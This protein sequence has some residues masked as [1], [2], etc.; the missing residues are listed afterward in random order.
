MME[1]PE[2]VTIASQLNDTVR[3]KRIVAATA[4]HTPHRFAWYSGDPSSYNNLVS[5]KTVEGCAGYGSNVEIR[6]GD[7]LLSIGTFI[8]FHNTGEVRPKIHQLLLEFE[9]GSAISACAQLWGGFFCHPVG[10]KCGFPDVD[11]AREKPS[12]LSEGFNRKYFVLLFDAATQSLSA[13]AFLATQQRIPGL[14]NG[15]LQDILWKAKIHPKTKMGDSSSSSTEIL[16][17]SIKSVLGKM[18]EQGGRDTERDLFNHPGGYHTILS[19][20]TVGT[21]CP[22]CGALICKETYMGGAIY[23]CPDCQEI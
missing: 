9:D 6:A 3:G 21:P 8:L 17:H 18:V 2:A 22:E 12:P 7:R 15:V 19:K 4:G 11:I 1:Y 23:F 20:N 16:F 5:G 13:K 10:V 14:G